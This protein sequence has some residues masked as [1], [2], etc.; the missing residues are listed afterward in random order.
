MISPSSQT[1]I[2][3]GSVTDSSSMPVPRGLFRMRR[4]GGFSLV[5]VTMA[6]GIVSFAF[7][8]TLGLIPTGLKTFRSAIDTSVGG[9]I[10]QRMINE[11]QQTDFD[12]LLDRTNLPNYPSDPPV[13][14]TFRSPT[15]AT[16]AVRYFDD[17]GSECLDAQGK[18]SVTSKTIYHVNT[19]IMPVTT[20]VA[21]GTSPAANANLATI[22][23]QIAKNPGNA[24]L[25]MTSNLWTT[26]S[27][28]SL[29]T[30][31]T[32]VARNK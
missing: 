22:T 12:T 1:A 2:S 18:P 11:A 32:L 23:V 16:P 15:V 8:T 21:T 20:L 13:G 30:H 14:F 3:D 9:Q 10:F 5:E 7:L 17:Q 24:A 27:G 31:S 6:I 28:V 29:L 25:T 19:R 26:N 4:S